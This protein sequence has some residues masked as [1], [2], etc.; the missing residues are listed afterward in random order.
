[1]RTITKKIELFARVV[2]IKKRKSKNISFIQNQQPKTDNVNNKKN[3]SINKNNIKK[4]SV[5]TYENHAHIVIGPR[6][7]GKI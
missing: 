3:L 1:M 2:I 7:V 5:S 4:P 6:I